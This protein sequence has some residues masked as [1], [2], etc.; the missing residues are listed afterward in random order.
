MVTLAR[1]RR[2]GGTCHAEPS[3]PS[4]ASAGGIGAG[5][6]LSS[7][8]YLSQVQEEERHE[9]DVY[10]NQKKG[11]R[12]EEEEEERGERKKPRSKGFLPPT[13][14]PLFFRKR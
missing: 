5:E 8:L 13:T 10:A 7:S 6:F 11:R 14:L 12:K 1:P 9:E 4:V 2:I 3:T